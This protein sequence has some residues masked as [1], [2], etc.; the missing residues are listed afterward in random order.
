VSTEEALLW[1]IRESPDDPLPRQALGDWLMEQDDPR[2][3]ALGELIQIQ[4][5]MDALPK[6]SP[7]RLELGIR[8]RELL[9]RNRAG[10]GRMF[11]PGMDGPDGLF[12]QTGV[13]RGQFA[14]SA[15][16]GRWSEW[17]ERLRGWRWVESV[18][19]S[20]NSGLELSRTPVARSLIELHLKDQ[21]DSRAE[22]VD[23]RWMADAAHLF[24]HLQRLTVPVIRESPF[25]V[26]SGSHLRERLRSLTMVLPQGPGAFT[27]E[28]PTLEQ[29][30]VWPGTTDQGSLAA[31]SEVGHFPALHSFFLA[32]LR[33]EDSISRVLLSDWQATL[34]RLPWLGQLRSLILC[35]GG[36]PVAPALLSGRLERLFLA[37]TVLLPGCVSELAAWSGLKRLRSLELHLVRSG[38][39]L[40]PLFRGDEA[41]EVRRFAL[42]GP[43]GT[44]IGDLLRSPLLSSVESVDI[45]ATLSA[46]E[47]RTL[48]RSP[49]MGRVVHLCLQET[50]A[51]WLA[52]SRLLWLPSLRILELPGGISGSR[53]VEAFLAWP[54][55]SKLLRLNVMGNHLGDDGAAALA[56]CRHLAGLR[57]LDLS[58]ND[59]THE[60]ANALARSKWL[61]GLRRFRMAGA[62]L[63][64][65]T[66]EIMVKSEA[67]ANLV[68]L[69][70]SNCR[71][72]GG[73]RELLRE[74]F[75][76]ALVM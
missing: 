29:L 31:L 62:A 34:G 50:G 18:A 12:G 56:S 75:G 21:A 45:H 51:D 16:G 52:A 32:A 73:A 14:V 36:L 63:R 10:W 8:D 49:I 27:G 23:L 60:G 30:S 4:C 37:N 25:S 33:N 55:I 74:R 68:E 47:A 58:N 48:A 15:V 61:M 76:E 41:G 28:W 46:M 43:H 39:G 26:P 66:I 72:S 20:G 69:D 24:P 17:P 2:E 7:E 19:L 57:E 40:A 13:W 44:P 38:D 35:G 70:L 54:E 22:P 9:N 67:F 42:T 6:W 65:R 71:V 64:Q 53:Q 1:A 5:R 3:Q 59:I 11:F